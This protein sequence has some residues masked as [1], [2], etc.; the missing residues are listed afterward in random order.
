VLHADVETSVFYL[1]NTIHYSLLLLL[2][3]LPSAQRIG[4]PKTSR[5]QATT[6]NIVTCI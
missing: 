6:D 2:L 3:L 5:Q 4:L 1:A